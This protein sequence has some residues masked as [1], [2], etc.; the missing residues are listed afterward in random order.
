MCLSR[1]IDEATSAL[2][3]TSRILV[4]EAIKHWRRNKTTIVITHDLSQIGSDDFAFVMKDGQVAQQGYRSQLEA[5]VSGEFFAMMGAQAAGGVPEKEDP[6]SVERMRAHEEEAIQIV[7][8]EEGQI[9]GDLEKVTGNRTIKH[10]S[11]LRTSMAAGPRASLWMFDAVADLTGHGSSTTDLPTYGNRFIP[12]EEFNGLSDPFADRPR[13]PSTVAIEV[14]PPPPSYHPLR[15]QYSLQFSPLSPTAP[16]LTSTVCEDEPE[17]DEFKT[18]AVHASNA[19]QSRRGPYHR[20]RPSL[21]KEAAHGHI[22]SIHMEK[23]KKGVAQKS[24]D[25]P[26]KQESS[27]PPAKQTGFWR[28]IREVFPTIPNKF[29]LLIGAL[30]CAVGGATTPVFSF[31]I[32][33]LMVEV[34]TGATDINAVNMY[35]GI[36]LAI[37]ATDGIAA[38]GRFFTLE[39]VGMS[40]ITRIRKF[41]FSYVLAQDKKWFDKSENSPARIMQI[42]VKDGDDAR[43]LIATVFSQAIMVVT[44][45]S[46]GL[47]WAFVIGWQLTLVGLAIAPVFVITMAVQA[48]LVARCEYRNKRA[49]EDV[50]KGYYDV[51]P[52]RISFSDLFS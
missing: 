37:A 30:F 33:R 22:E 21:D 19:V 46:V 25:H 28:L 35:G 18:V 6:Y 38:G 7:Q 31:V 16:S 49:R 26:A 50:A 24:Q 23:L 44:M 39:S 32:S 4:F 36:A 34:S 12:I 48:N 51:R 8:Q 2:D 40:W 47:L 41:C 29:G 20:S 3:A 43:S 27:A 9:E 10:R 17:F 5:D 14:L 42:L 11:G 15:H 45:L 13:R 52:L 1:F